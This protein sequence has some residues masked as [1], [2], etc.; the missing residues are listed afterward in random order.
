MHIIR[1]WTGPGPQVDGHLGRYL[2][3]ATQVYMPRY[4]WSPAWERTDPT[5]AGLEQGA[6]V[7]HS[8][9]FGKEGCGCRGAQMLLINPSLPDGLHKLTA[10]STPAPGELSYTTILCLLPAA[11]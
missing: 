10:V 4:R 8:R 5:V 11:D 9:E 1:N 3:L 7:T 6:P 2:G